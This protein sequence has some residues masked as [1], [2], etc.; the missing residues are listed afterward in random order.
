MAE[1]LYE[2]GVGEA[3]AA[4][5]SRGRI[6]K[7]RIEVDGGGP[8]EGAI[9]RARLAERNGPRT[10]KVVLA[11]KQGEALVEPLPPG[12]T[13]GAA[14]TVRIVREGIVERGKRRLPKAVPA[15]G[16][17]RPGPT[18]RE[19]IAAT[20]VPVIELRPHQHDALEDAGWSEVIDEA[21]TGD[22]AFPGGWLRMAVTPAMTLFDVDGAPPHGAL[23]I[24]AAHA[25]AQAIERHGIGGSIGIDFPT[26]A[27]KAERN[28]AAAAIDAALP[29]P[30][31]RTAI[32]GF[33]FLQLVRRRTRASLP[34]QIM[35]DPAGHAAR[36][37]LRIAE[38]VPPPAPDTH[39]VSEP[40]AR[41][42]A[43]R[44]DLIDELA[45]RTGVAARF[46]AEEPR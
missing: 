36:A 8:R 2:A 41:W 44:P 20:G 29:Q 6:W 16:A 5:V 9:V 15:E 22:I 33:G 27:D 30:F 38:R 39:I 12:I 19:R 28:A 40:A 24:A 34:E 35:A 21:V 11:D 1:W 46:V 7:A 26:L 17:P 32:N 18:L 45:R 14:L 25:A 4:L 42:L 13:Q 3:R 37:A 31:E 43:R 23:S 10:G